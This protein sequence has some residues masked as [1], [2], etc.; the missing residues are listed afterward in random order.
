MVKRKKWQT[1]VWWKMFTNHI[2]TQ[3]FP[4]EGIKNTHQWYSIFKPPNKKRTKTQRGTWPEWVYRWQINIGRCSTSLDITGIQIKAAVRHHYRPWGQL[5]KKK[6]KTK[7]TTDEK[8]E[9]QALSCSAGCDAKWQN[10]FRQVFW[11]LLIKLNMS[12]PTTYDLTPGLIYQIELKTE[13]CAKTFFSPTCLQQ[14]NSWSLNTR[15]KPQ[16][17]QLANIGLAKKFICVFL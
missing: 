12:Y 9:Q 17:L 3:D 2:S 6:K 4:L 5:K 8:M 11:K 13:V 16:V 7:P 1:T 10:Y 15:K 14:L